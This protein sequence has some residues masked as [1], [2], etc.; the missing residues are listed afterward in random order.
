VD[1]VLHDP[2]VP[3]TLLDLTEPKQ[4]RV[5]IDLMHSRPPEYIHLGMPCGTASRARERPVATSK[6]LQGAPQPPPLH[7]ADH[8][9]GLPHINPEST[10][11]IR[12]KKA[13]QLYSFVIDILLIAMKYNIAIS[14]ENPYRSWFWAA[15]LALVQAQNNPALTRFWDSLTEVFS[16]TVVMEV[17]AKRAPDGSQPQVSSKCSQQSARMIMITCH[18]RFTPKMDPGFSI[19]PVKQHTLACSRK[20]LR[21]PSENFYRLRSFL[22]PHHLTLD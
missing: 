13:N 9:L 21:R 5:L 10:S 7:S 15:I 17:N 4:Q 20:G 8:P 1:H 3:V 22:L 18:T 19:Q 6:V 16:I 12:L 2:Q 11:G 14:L